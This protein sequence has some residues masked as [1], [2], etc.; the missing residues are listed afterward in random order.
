MHRGTRPRTCRRRA[1]ACPLAGWS[2]GP[3]VPFRHEETGVVGELERGA[4]PFLN[5]CHSLLLV[6]APQTYRLSLPTFLTER[7]RP[8]ALLVA[9]AKGA[10]R[11]QELDEVA[12]ANVAQPL[13]EEGVGVN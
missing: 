2:D 5:K 9:A 3:G 12:V 6:R 7:P 13:L 10:E 4:D 1:Y 8:P 11:L